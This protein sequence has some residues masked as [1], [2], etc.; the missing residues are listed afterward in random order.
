MN[1]CRDILS[2]RVQRG[3]CFYVSRFLSYAR[4]DIILW[5]LAYLFLAYSFA[6][7]AA[8]LS[9][10]YSRSP[11]VVELQKPPK[12]DAP[13]AVALDVELRDAQSAAGSPDW[14]N[15]TAPG[16]Y[17]GVMAVYGAPHPL[18]IYASNNYAPVDMLFVDEYGAIVQIAPG[19][20][21]AELKDPIVCETPVLAL[22]YLNGG[23]AASFGIQPGDTLTHTLF[24]KKPAV[25][26]APKETTPSSQTPP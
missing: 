23:A 3:I 5:N 17:K 14:F 10:L 24:K 21:P 19:I 26:T 25:L 12:P 2:S 1:G 4:N 22:L 20:V 13:A 8:P 11:V 9:L 6:A 15:F 18:T 7:H 16:A